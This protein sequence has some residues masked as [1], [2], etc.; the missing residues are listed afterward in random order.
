VAGGI[1]QRMEMHSLT[2]TVY[3]RESFVYA[4]DAAAGSPLKTTMISSIRSF[5]YMRRETPIDV[6]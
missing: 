6:S 3:E 2:Q 4:L 1:S 5:A